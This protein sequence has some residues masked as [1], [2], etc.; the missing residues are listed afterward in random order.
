MTPT[1][2]LEVVALAEIPLQS[3]DILYKCWRNRGCSKFLHY[4][5]WHPIKI[6]NIREGWEGRIVP[7]GFISQVSGSLKN[8]MQNSY[9]QVASHFPM[10]YVKLDYNSETINY[11]WLLL[12]QILTAIFTILQVTY[13]PISFHSFLAAHGHNWG[14]RLTDFFIASAIAA[15]MVWRITCGNRLC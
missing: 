11:E 9:C 10:A 8:L 7:E 1:Y 3:R 6:D 13:F 14:N 12:G 5:N 15:H 4:L 2:C